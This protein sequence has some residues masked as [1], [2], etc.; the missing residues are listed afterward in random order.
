MRQ[1]FGYCFTW[2]CC[3]LPEATCCDD[4]VHCCPSN[5][6]VCDVTAGRCLNKPGAG[7]DDS[8]EWFTKT[9]ADKVKPEFYVVVGHLPQLEEH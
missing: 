1:Y 9:P 3:P 8:S 5:L 4:H 6:P 2:A 7:F